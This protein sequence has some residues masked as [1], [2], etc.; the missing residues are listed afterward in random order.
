MSR[1]R[2]QDGPAIVVT[3][4][5]DVGNRKGGLLRSGEGRDS[6]G[7]E[8]AMTNLEEKIG[9]KLDQLV[10]KYTLI[11]QQLEQTKHRSEHSKEP[12]ENSLTLNSNIQLR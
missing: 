1:S 8:V 3:Q 4:P 10:Q 5:A 12:A 9:L 2:Y 11:E 7:M 6:S